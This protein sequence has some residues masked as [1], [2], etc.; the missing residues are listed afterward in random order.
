MNKNELAEKLA[1]LSLLAKKF[2]H[3]VEQINKIMEEE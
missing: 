1:E 2:M 3:V